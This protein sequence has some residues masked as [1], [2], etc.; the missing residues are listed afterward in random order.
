MARRLID[1]PSLRA[2]KLVEKK[3]VV[4]QG[5]ELEEHLAM[6]RQHK[7]MERMKEQLTLVVPSAVFV[8]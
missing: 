8:C 5:E 6:L 7:A 1:N 3:R 4:L 2:F